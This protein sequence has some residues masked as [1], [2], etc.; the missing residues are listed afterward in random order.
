M[1][2]VPAEIGDGIESGRE[3]SPG[4]GSEI[5]F[6]AKGVIVVIEWRTVMLF[7]IDAEIVSDVAFGG[8]VVDILIVAP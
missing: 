7:E 1:S 6:H 4:R 5:I 3:K 8:V 2:M